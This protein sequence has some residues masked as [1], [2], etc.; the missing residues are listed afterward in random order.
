[1]SGSQ[2]QVLGTM[3]CLAGAGHA[4][5]YSVFEYSLA[6][7]LAGVAVILM[8]VYVIRKAPEWAPY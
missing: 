5:Y 4:I 2:L 1:M 3:M 6:Y 8:G 7:I